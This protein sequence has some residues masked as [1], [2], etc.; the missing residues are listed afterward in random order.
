MKGFDLGLSLLLIQFT[1]YIV[2]TFFYK[3]KICFYKLKIYI[4]NITFVFSKANLHSWC[5]FCSSFNE[6]KWICKNNFLSMKRLDDSNW[7]YSIS[8]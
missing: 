3:E 2:K 5:C 4:S 8:Q 6:I 7:C 1:D